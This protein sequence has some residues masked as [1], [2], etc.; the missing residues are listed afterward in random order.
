MFNKKKKVK[1]REKKCQQCFAYVSSASKKCKFCGYR[2][3]SSGSY[4]VGKIK[5]ALQIDRA[6]KIVTA[7]NQKEPERFFTLQEIEYLVQPDNIK[8]L[9]FLTL[10]NINLLDET[11]LL[12]L[13]NML[14]KMDGHG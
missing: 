13:G 2:F 6:F 4:L 3:E 1:Y 14:T 7:K 9:M 8:I 5:Q 10:D 11:A 12:E